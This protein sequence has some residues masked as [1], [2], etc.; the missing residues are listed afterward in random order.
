MERNNADKEKL[1]ESIIST[2]IEILTSINVNIMFAQNNNSISKQNEK[3]L[4][5]AHFLLK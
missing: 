1:M 4:I 3:F 2:A 5:N